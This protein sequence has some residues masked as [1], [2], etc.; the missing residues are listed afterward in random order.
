MIDELAVGHEG[1]RDMQPQST[2]HHAAGTTL[3]PR[4][5][6]RGP[7]AA[8]ATKAVAIAVAMGFAAALGV[9]SAAAAAT[10]PSISAPAIRTGFGTVTITGK[11]RPGAKVYLY[12]TAISINN[13]QPAEDWQNPAG[14]FVKVSANS[15]GNYRIVRHV[16]TGFLFSVRSDGVMS[17]TRRVL[18][19]IDPTMWLRSTKPG[20]VTVGLEVSPM[21]EG[22][23]VRV[24]RANTGGGWS[25]VATGVTDS[26]GGYS[27]TLQNQGGGTHKSY[28]VF[29]GGD[30]ANG[31][32]SNFS[33]T[34]K[35]WV[36]R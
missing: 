36:V 32:L 17:A 18:V 6:R 26:V 9:T 22:L 31:V 29:V 24:Q 33:A 3:S 15:L 8:L 14:G 30:P 4:P 13:M 27:H 35:V 2:P 25:T 28:R 23:A 1:T 21:Q 20:A 19:R 10:A 11:A 7:R 16:D 34:R 5:A 12:E